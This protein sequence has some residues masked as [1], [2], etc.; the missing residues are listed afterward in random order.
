LIN[1]YLEEIN[2][3]VE[4]VVK[5]GRGRQIKDI[6]YADTIDPKHKCS[7]CKKGLDEVNFNVIKNTLKP[8]TRNFC[9]VCKRLR[10]LPK[11]KRKEL[12]RE[13]IKLYF[14]SSL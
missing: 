5:M 11:W 1:H 6:K 13:R 7:S 9:N 10:K 12:I 3:D 14:I 8:Y 2:A 4:G